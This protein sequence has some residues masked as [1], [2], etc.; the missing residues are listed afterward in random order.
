MRKIAICTLYGNYNYGNKLQ[1]Y[2]VQESIRKIDNCEVINFKNKDIYSIKNNFKNKIKFILGFFIKKY[3][4]NE[5][6]KERLANFKKFDSFINNTNYYINKNHPN[7]KNINS[8]DYFI[9]GSDQVWNPK[10]DYPYNKLKSLYLLDFIDDDNKKIS[11]SASFGISELSHDSKEQVCEYLSKFKKISVREQAAKEII[12]SLTTRNDVEVLLDPTMLLKSNE[13][14]KVARKPIQIDSLCLNDE[15][16]ILNYFLGNM[17]E[18][19]MSEIKNIA[20]KY[21][22]KIINILDKND[23]FYTCGPSEFVWLEKNA[24]LICTDSFHSSVFAILYKKPFVVFNRDDGQ[25]GKNSMNSRLE[26]LLKKF[27]LQDRYYKKN[28]ITDFIKCDYSKTDEILDVERK[29]MINFLHESLDLEET[30]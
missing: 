16:Y 13:W 30:K 5:Q 4:L 24:F 28:F 7:I 22:C 3:R 1:N 10:L 26:T 15:K 19:R 25:N 23:P 8:F 11:F 2:A 12:E 14:D 17:N 20:I 29:K 18:S 9:V 21:N 27:D 6:E